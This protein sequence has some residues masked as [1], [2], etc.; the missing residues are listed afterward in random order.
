[1]AVSLTALLAMTAC[2]GDSDSGA[3]SA[4][5]AEDPF[6]ELSAAA[7]AEGGQLNYYFIGGEASNHELFEAFK[8]QYPFVD[9]QVSGGDPFALIERVLTENRAGGQVADILQGGPLED[10]ILSV[11]NTGITRAVRP[12]GEASV[13]EELRFP[14]ANFI[15]PD[16]F[17]FHLAYNTNEVEEADVPTSLEELTQPEWRGR[18]GIDLEQ[19]DWFAGELAYYGEEEGM[20]LMQALA[21]NEPVAFNGAEGQEQLAAGVLPVIVNFGSSGLARYIDEGAPID[22]A[23]LDHIIAQPDIYIPIEGSPNPAT[24]ELFF[25]WM[26][27]EPA[28]EVLSEGAFK[29]P[30]LEGVE[31]PLQDVCPEGCELFWETTE[32]FGDYD[33]RVAQFQEL[34]QP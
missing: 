19:I 10:K 33:Q 32:N 5:V 2:G 25:E 34:F 29:N 9:F 18:F 14:D 28:Q 24:T 16:Y 12:A 4:V 20:A 13:P 30:V 15:V 3:A 31:P 7:E 6:P 22:Y 26:F 1:M 11:D 27:T 23:Q 17:T 8:A 21:A